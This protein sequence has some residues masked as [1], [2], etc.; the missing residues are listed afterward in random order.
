MINDSERWSNSEKVRA[1]FE[2]DKGYEYG[3]VML[4]ESLRSR[5]KMGVKNEAYMLQLQL[6]FFI[7]AAM[8]FHVTSPLSGFIMYVEIAM[9]VILW[10]SLKCCST[11][12]GDW[13]L[14]RLVEAM[15]LVKRHES[16]DYDQVLNVAKSIKFMKSME[17]GDTFLRNVMD[18][19]ALKKNHDTYSYVQF[20]NVAKSIRFVKWMAVYAT[21]LFAL[22]YNVDMSPITASFTQLSESNKVLFSL[23]GVMVV[24]GLLSPFVS[25]VYVM[26][27]NKSDS[28]F[29]LRCDEFS[30]LRDEFFERMGKDGSCPIDEETRVKFAK[31]RLSS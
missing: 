17:G 25:A 26:F 19:M 7:I 14:S 13:F 22:F 5:V 18:Y 8:I 3:Y 30:R 9:F 6:V 23:G 12:P 21:M 10:F 1:Y 11:E 20:F 24:M 2:L 29:K 31:E 28:Y 4:V 27:K 15:E 16:Y